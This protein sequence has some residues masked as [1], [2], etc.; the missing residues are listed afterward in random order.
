MRPGARP[1]IADLEGESPHVLVQADPEAY[2]PALAARRLLGLLE[3]GEAD[4]ALP[5]SNEP[6]CQAARREAP[7]PY[8]TPA[9]LEE[10][11]RAVAAAAG[12]P[13]RQGPFR[14]PV[15]AARR[16]ALAGFPRDL[17]LDAAVER[18]A[19]LG[20]RVRIDP[21]AYLHRYGEMD[22]Q[23]RED[24]AARIPEGSRVVLDVG[25]SRGATAAALR[26][27]G[28]T[29]IVGIEPDP[30][31]ARQAARRYDRVLAVPLES[32][33]EDFA[34]RFD[35]IL[36]GDVLEHLADPSAALLR[37]RPWLSARGAVVASVP[38]IGHWSVIA[39]L[40]RGHFDYVPYSIL[41]GTHVRF[42]TRRTL[43]DLFE[44]CGFESPRIETVRFAPSPFGEKALERLRRVPGA[45]DDLD[46]VEFVAVARREAG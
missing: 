26:R 21:G 13:A 2:L 42:F 39:D 44:A 25:C 36:F 37:V 27:G 7:F 28:V 41:S 15:F 1:T 38:N 23:A 11:A 3:S 33:S 20:R 40:L 29:E 31:D 19:V 30:G 16:E 6:W 8:H 22:G 14:S 43:R 18:A 17:P 10:A 34:G 35:A 4:V 9:L 46:V 5:V 24:L 32:V 45:S 12:E